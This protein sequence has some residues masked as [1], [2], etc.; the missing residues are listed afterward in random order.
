MERADRAHGIRGASANFLTL[1]GQTSMLLFQILGARLF[2]AASWGAYAFGLSA[3][4]ICGRLGLMG[5]DKGILVFVAARRAQSDWDGAERAIATGIR[6]S[7]ILG[8]LLAVGV[9]AGAGTVGRLYG[10]AS[11]GQALRVMAVAIPMVSLTTILLAATMARKTMSYNLLV[12]GAV[13]PILRVSLILGLGLTLGSLGGLV[14]VHVIAAAGT[15]AVALWAFTRLYPFRRALATVAR[16]PFDTS[17]VRY[18]IPLALSEFVNSFLAQTNVLVL[19]KFRSAEDVGVYSAAMALSTAVSFLRGAFDTVLAPIAA[20]ALVQGD[21]ARLARNLQLYC[22]IILTFAVPLAGLMIVG[23]PV[24]M[25]F[26]GPVFEKGRLTLA[27]LSLGHVVNASMGLC[28]WTL[29]A[30]GRSRIVLVNNVGAFLVNILL[31]V[32]LVP[33][34]GMEGAALAA[35]ATITVLQAIIAFESF[36]VARVQPFSAGFIRLVVLGAA[37]VGGE[38][39]LYAVLPGSPLVRALVT[40]VGGSAIFFLLAWL[41]GAEDERAMLRSLVGRR[42]PAQTGRA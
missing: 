11:F 30:S 1:V 20:E 22:R 33:R 5:A 40:V 13:E 9:F 32:A 21:N 34:L 3:L 29:L 14:L 37:V 25:G 7:L 35:A 41:T 12:K 6:M 39:A 24:L 18:A 31:C 2:G 16:S 36:K 4:E 28:N 10:Q 15:A 8:T 19:G 26:H 23:G 17:L 42:T 27:I 38:L